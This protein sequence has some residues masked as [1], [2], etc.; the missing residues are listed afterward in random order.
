[1][2][3]VTNDGERITAEGLRLIP[4]GMS[5]G[6]LN[7]FADIATIRALVGIYRREKPDIV[8]HV[9]LKPVLYGSWAAWISGTRGVVNAFCG[10]GY[11]FIATGWRTRVLRG[12]YC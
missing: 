9:A 6:G 4:I 12:L 10:L 2:T 11:L 3:R 8:H 5:R 1:A 7:P